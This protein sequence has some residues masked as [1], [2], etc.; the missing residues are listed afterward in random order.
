MAPTIDWPSGVITIPKSDSSLIQTS[1]IER[2]SLDLAQLI[3]DIRALEASE[4]GR[5][6]FPLVASYTSEST[7]SGT[8]F[9]PQLRIRE[10]YYSVT[11]E[12]GPYQLVL[13]GA[14][15]NIS[16]VQ[17]LN[18]V[19]VIPQNSAGLVSLTEIN[20]AL[21]SVND[22]VYYDAI[23]GTSGT[24][25][26]VGQPDRPSNDLADVIAIASRD[27]KRKISISSSLTV[28]EDLAGY[29][30]VTSGTNNL[31]T[32]TGTDVTGLSVEDLMVTG[33]QN[34]VARFYT[35]SVG[36]LTDFDGQMRTCGLAQSPL[37]QTSA[38]ITIADTTT[39]DP[40]LINCFESD[41]SGLYPVI[42][43]G[44]GTSTQFA[45]I[46]YQGRI[47]LQNINNANKRVEINL[48][49]GQ[50][51]LDSSC[52]AGTVVLDGYGGS[53]VLNGATCTVESA[54]FIS[55][56]SGSGAFTEDDR[57]TLNAANTNSQTSA[58]NTAIL[59]S[60]LTTARA[61][62]LDLLQD[63][64]DRVRRLWQKLGLDAANPV[65]L[66]KSGN[67]TTETFDDVEVRHVDNGVDS[68]TVTRQP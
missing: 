68:V 37:P 48:S 25:S 51:F 54:N 35:C 28:D 41:P 55:P 62:A 63:V 67:T 3:L 29:T 58:T 45:L 40:R 23:T 17:N 34:G 7:L 13:S 6:G 4:D 49:G 18:E 9:A 26:G 57:T 46:G 12:N 39:Q 44:G 38:T 15:S 53:I 43:L 8:V 16:D 1:P 5:G 66:T 2:R 20:N 42:D 50:V 56:A 30:V 24:G 64:S 10:E 27:S 19:Q 36:N 60:R 61:A 22:T 47:G 31:L 33:V 65:T 11:F 14:N 21:K 32:L 52:T 59:A